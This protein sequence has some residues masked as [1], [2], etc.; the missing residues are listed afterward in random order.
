MK[1]ASTTAGKPV[2]ARG[3]RRTPPRGSGLGIYPLRAVVYLR[4]STLGQVRT[5]RDGEG[6]SIPAQREACLRKIDELGATLV[7]E[8][9]DAGESRT[10]DIERHL[11]L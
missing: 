4:V 7:G 2:V 10:P 11:A 1:D 9:V 6:F 5:N 3:Y 8:Y